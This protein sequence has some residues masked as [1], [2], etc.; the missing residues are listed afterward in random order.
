MRLVG[1]PDQVRKDAK[2]IPT[3]L[4]L[5]EHDIGSRQRGSDGVEVTLFP[6]NPQNTCVSN[7]QISLEPGH[8]KLRD[9]LVGQARYE[10]IHF[11]I[12]GFIV[13]E[14]HSDLYHEGAVKKCSE[15][16]R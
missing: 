1:H 4:K 11:G 10:R 6:R 15:L 2:A 13:E 14:R 12:A 16:E 7:N 9:D 3:S 5:S 8:R